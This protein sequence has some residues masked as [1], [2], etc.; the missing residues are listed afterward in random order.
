VS[1]TAVS[2]AGSAHVTGLYMLG[3]RHHVMRFWTLVMILLQCLERLPVPW[4]VA[5]KLC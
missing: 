2:V 1:W 4:T 3:Y 5:H